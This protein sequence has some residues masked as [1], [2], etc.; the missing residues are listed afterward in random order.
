MK[1]RKAF[2]LSAAL[3]CGLL[4]AG[5][6]LAQSSTSYDLSWN[7]IAGGGGPKGSASYTVNSTIG[8]VAIGASDS[9]SYRLGAGYWYGAAAPAPPLPPH[10]IYLPTIMKHYAS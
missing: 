1:K 4:V 6:A 2:V 5:V 3:F 10:K 7:V 8:Q 9:A